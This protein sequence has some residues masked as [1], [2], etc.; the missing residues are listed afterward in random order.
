MIDY[1]LNR[2]KC[3]TIALYVRVIPMSG[4]VLNRGLDV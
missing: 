4:Y 2:S 3:K 1:S